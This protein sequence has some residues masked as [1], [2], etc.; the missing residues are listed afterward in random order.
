MYHLLHRLLR[1]EGE[2]HK[3]IIS[4]SEARQQTWL[5]MT[6]HGDN[7]RCECL[8]VLIL[9]CLLD[10]RLLKIPSQQNKQSAMH[11]QWAMQAAESSLALCCG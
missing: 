5:W 2:S 3:I 10:A 4:I 1:P 8:L 6:G 11:E 9:P 7:K